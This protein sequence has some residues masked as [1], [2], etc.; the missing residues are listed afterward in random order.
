MK[1]VV[2]RTGRPIAPLLE[3]RGDFVNWYAKTLGWPT[4]RFAEIDALSGESYPTATQIDG[5]IITGSVSSIQDYES[6]SISATRWVKTVM[7]A[8]IPILGICYGHQML[9]HILGSPVDRNPNGR[10]IGVSMVQQIGQD[11]LFQGLPETF[12]VIQTHMDA[13]LEGSADMRIIA[14][15]EKTAVQAIA[16]GDMVRGVQ[17]HPECDADA[18]AHYVRARAHLIESESGPDAVEDI[19]AGIQPVHTGVTI[20]RNFVAHFMGITNEAP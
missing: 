4:D 5:L 10:E 1:P 9:G 15:N 6:W 8:K 11:P 18:I 13:V 14:K 19:L 7:E 2:L 20:L 17:W 12:P 16:Y 3:S